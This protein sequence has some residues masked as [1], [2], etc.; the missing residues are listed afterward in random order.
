MLVQ[1]TVPAARKLGLALLVLACASLFAPVL[2][3]A[4][5][6]TQ[7]H[8]KKE[9]LGQYQK[10][11]AEAQIQS[12]LINKR[13]RS[14]RMTLK[15]GRHVDIKYNAK[16]EKKFAASL[17]AHH[18]PFSVLSPAAALAEYNAKPVHHKLRYIVGG[19]V[20]VV[21]VLVVAGLLFYRRR[22]YSEE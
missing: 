1:T 15:D 11:L 9:T 20:I 13:I 5:A 2:A 16:E 6:A 18:V 21:I 17:R 19:I 10:Q 3:P 22:R 8:Y 4:G 12:I 14:L 7:I